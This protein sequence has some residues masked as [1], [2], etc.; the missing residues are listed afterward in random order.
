MGVTEPIYVAAATDA[1][2]RTAA[3]A[4]FNN[5]GGRVKIPS[6]T[7]TLAS[8]LPLYAGVI[9]E[10]VPVMAT[11]GGGPI[12]GIGGTILL[13]DG[14]FN[15]FEYNPTDTGTPPATWTALDT[16]CVRGIGIQDITLNN[17]LYGVKIGAKYIGGCNFG[18]FGRLEIMNCRAW[19]FWIENYEQSTFDRII[20]GSCD[21]GQIAAVGSGANVWN[22]GNSEWIH[23]FSNPGPLSR[24][25]CA[26]ARGANSKLNQD[27]WISCEVN[28]SGQN[29]SQAATM[30][31]GAANITVT[32]GSK[33]PLDMPMVFDTTANGFTANQVYFVV[34]R[35]SNVI[36]V[37][38]TM[39]GTALVATGATALNAVSKDFAN[40]EWVGLDAG[41]QITY[42]AALNL[43]LEGS[44]T[45]R[46]VMQ[47]CYGCHQIPS[48]IIH[49]TEVKTFAV[50]ASQ[51][52]IF[53]TTE[54]GTTFD[55]D[56]GSSSS[57]YISQDGWRFGTKVLANGAS[58]VPGLGLATTGLTITQTTPGKVAYANY[59]NGAGYG[60][61]TVAASAQMALAWTSNGVDQAAKSLGWDNNGNVTLYPQ[62]SVTPANNG[63]MNFQLT[64]NTSLVIKVKGSDGTVRSTT[65]TLA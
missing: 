32:D 10:G 34:S 26:W 23:C 30:A 60:A 52:C 31:N 28:R 17:F 62:T 19:G 22:G 37:S 18:R 35:A 45:A 63:E 12:V 40:M 2:I 13:G 29:V 43:D 44:S 33:F 55:L 39:R 50:R 61:I 7:I 6:G 4:A 24:G 49:G 16:T 64:S 57:T 53:G 46:V 1:S 14:T 47:N 58:N 11:Q 59:V 51:G 8:P 3:L 21:I 20:V 48:G 65:L 5:G 41:C 42:F 38:D 27:T 56:G 15:G 54:T 36:Q 9:Y 25:I